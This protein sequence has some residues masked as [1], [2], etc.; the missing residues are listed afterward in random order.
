MSSSS[1][2]EIDL[3]IPAATMERMPRYLMQL[4]RFKTAGLTQVSSQMLGESLRIKDTQIRKDLSYFGVF[5]RARYGYNIDALIDA[6]EKILGLNL[7][8]KL[9][10]VGFG[11]IGRA[12]TDYHGTECHNFCVRWI[13]DVN[14]AV[15]GENVGGH[16]VQS[17]DRLEVC[18]QTDSVDIALITTPDD[19]ALE[20]AQRLIQVGV[21][22]IYN[23]TAAEIP[24]DANVFVENAQIAFGL[25]K[26]A[27]R[28]AG[29]WP[30]KR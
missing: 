13:F 15:I 25:Y 7:Q 11:R 8:Y 17:L 12:L 2:F 4:Y 21:H 29:Q 24:H 28:L 18:L 6:V 1:G 20:V 27:H 30:R 9:A 26:L 10:I 23:F 16:V 19:A 3:N 14:P 5:G 22:A